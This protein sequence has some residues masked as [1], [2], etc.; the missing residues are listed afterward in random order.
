MAEP[1]T[2]ASG[3]VLVLAPYTLTITQFGP[4]PGRYP[5]LDTTYTRIARSQRGTPAR[6]GP[7][8][9][10]P[11][12]WNFTGRLNLDQQETLRRMEASYWA[13]R[14]AFTLYDYTNY[15]N[16]NGTTR[17][18]AIAPNSTSAQ[19]GTTI[20]YYP[21]WQAEPT[22]GFEWIEQTEGWDLIEFQFTE[23]EV[24]AA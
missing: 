24:V 9:R 12:I 14:R 17:T 18:R 8:S 15:W 19:D 3:I 4:R 1:T 21:Q 23:T 6:R 13:I 10:P 16:E 20:L 7:Q 2:T 11:A 22:Q 5:R